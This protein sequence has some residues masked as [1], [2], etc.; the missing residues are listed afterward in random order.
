M[1][2]SNREGDIDNLISVVYAGSTIIWSLDCCSGIKSIIRI[3]SK[4]GKRNVFK[5][6]PKKKFLSK[7]FKLQ[8]E[9]DIAEK[10]AEEEAYSI[11][12]IL[13]DGSKRITD[14]V[15]RVP[16]PKS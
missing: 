12:Y 6:D 7:S 5:S 13:C 11:E 3:Y 10:E 14:P 15:I 8:L 1:L 9:N 16:P 4:E 2:D